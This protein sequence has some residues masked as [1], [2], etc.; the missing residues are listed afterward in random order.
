MAQKQIKPRCCNQTFVT[1][2]KELPSLKQFFVIFCCGLFILI[3]LGIGE[4]A[5]FLLTRLHGVVLFGVLHFS[6]VAR[7]MKVP[8]A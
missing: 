4:K 2:Q 6:C 1:W 5:P 7:G 8:S 3:Q